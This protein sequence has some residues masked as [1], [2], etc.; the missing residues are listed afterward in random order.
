[1]TWRGH[2]NGPEKI[3]GIPDKEKK[4]ECKCATTLDTRGPYTIGLE[5]LRA[6]QAKLDDLKSKV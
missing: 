3:I 4:L 5:E 1:M 6:T 2:S